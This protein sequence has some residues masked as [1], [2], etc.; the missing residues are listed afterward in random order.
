[1]GTPGL[2]AGVVIAVANVD[3]LGI[4]HLAIDARELGRAERGDLGQ[5][6][7]EG[8]WQVA[9]RVDLAEKHGRERGPV[10]FPRIPG[11]HHRGHLAQPGHDYRGAGIHDH[12][13]VRV[14]RGH[15]GD[16][17]VLR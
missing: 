13:G 7:R 6:F 2:I 14:G 9:G 1:M 12:H 10:A 15:R 4:L 8:H 11:V 16:Q 5:V 17:L 3:P